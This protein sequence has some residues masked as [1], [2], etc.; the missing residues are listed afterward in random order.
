TKKNTTARAMA[1]N[2]AITSIVLIPFAR[3]EP[4]PVRGS[5]PLKAS[6]PVRTVVHRF[7]YFLYHHIVA[8]AVVHLH[9]DPVPHL[10]VQKRFPDGRFRTH[11]AFQGISPHGGHD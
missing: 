2:T 11:K 4:L 10:V 6:Q 9:I 8:V 3:S 1:A 5:P 7:F